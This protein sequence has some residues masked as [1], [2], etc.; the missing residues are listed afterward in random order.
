MP[1]RVPG[2]VVVDYRIKA[3]LEVDPLR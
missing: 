2:K 1:R 3:L